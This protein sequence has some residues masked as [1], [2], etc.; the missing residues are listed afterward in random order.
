MTLP[1]PVIPLAGMTYDHA[2]NVAAMS[3]LESG[4]DYL[5]FLDSDVIPPPDTVPRLMAHNVPIVSGVYCRRSPPHAIPV[6]IKNKQW[7]T[8]F[9]ANALISVD[10][11]GA[12]CLLV[13]RDVFASLPPQRVGSHWFDWKVNL[14]GAPGFDEADCMSEDFTF[15]AHARKNGYKVLVDTSI[16]CKHVGLAE[17]G[18]GTFKPLECQNA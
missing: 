9:P 11:V 1:G 16:Q 3:C 17:A 12:G 15:C 10:V 18:F 8:S 2:R 13:H 5:F 4:A 6:M 14:R 7:V